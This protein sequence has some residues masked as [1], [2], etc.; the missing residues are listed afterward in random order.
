VCPK[1]PPPRSEDSKSSTRSLAVDQADEVA[2][3]D[4]VFVAETGAR[5]YC[6][7]Q[8]RILHVHG[9][10]RRDEL[11]LAGRDD[12]GAVDTGAQVH[13]RRPA[14]RVVGQRKF[15][16]QTRVEYFDLNRFQ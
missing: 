11:R 16:A 15:S 7:R 1:P 2:Q 9:E 10:A 5:Q 6:G 12:H 14:R 13:A 4:S 8:V 3:H